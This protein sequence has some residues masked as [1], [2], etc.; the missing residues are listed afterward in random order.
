MQC[1]GL[2]QPGSG[3]PPAAPSAVAMHQAHPLSSQGTDPT[4]PTPQWVAVVVP[5][6][7]AQLGP[8]ARPPRFATSTSAFLTG[9]AI[10]ELCGIVNMNCFDLT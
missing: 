3:A 2:A 9:K 6:G 10:K 4:D 1:G 7:A 5:V 8:G